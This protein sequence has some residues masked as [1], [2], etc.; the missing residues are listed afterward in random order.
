MMLGK[1]FILPCAEKI[2][3]VERAP[4]NEIGHRSVR[5]NEMVDAPAEFSGNSL[6][7]IKLR[8]KTL[9]RRSIGVK[10][11]TIRIEFQRL[12]TVENRLFVRRPA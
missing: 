11:S 1:F 4:I 2:L 3:D 5:V 10:H 9:P 6:H 7:G 8:V 12:A